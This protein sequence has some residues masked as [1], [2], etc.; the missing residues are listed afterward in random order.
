M[1]NIKVRSLNWFINTGSSPQ[2]SSR[3]Y[4]V[5]YTFEYYV[6]LT[7][8]TII[9][10]EKIIPI[11]HSIHF[12][13]DQAASTSTLMV[14][15][16]LAVRIVGRSLFQHTALIKYDPAS[17]SVSSIS[18]DPNLCHVKGFEISCKAPLN[19]Q[20]RVKGKCTI[21]K[22]QFN[23]TNLVVDKNFVRFTPT[24][25]V[26]TANGKTN[27]VFLICVAFKSTNLHMFEWKWKKIYINLLNEYDISAMILVHI[28]KILRSDFKPNSTLYKWLIRW[29]LQPLTYLL[30]NV[31]ISN[32]KSSNST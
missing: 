16:L 32:R 14:P 7:N 25:N 6:Q 27:K 10:W 3:S 24:C 13:H 29:S 18:G 21:K 9:A 26:F 5:P 12:A 22:T 4:S 11:P 19:P 17:S 1:V 20:L 30:W 23:T 15:W 28:M 8:D 31:I 2:H